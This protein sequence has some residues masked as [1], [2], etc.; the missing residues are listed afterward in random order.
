M[1]M[2]WHKDPVGFPMLAVERDLYVHWLP[3]TKIQFEYFMSDA[4]DRTFDIRWYEEALKLNARVTPMKIVTSNYWNTFLSGIQPAEAQRF[5]FWCGDGF[6][7]PSVEEW[8][9]A[10]RV[11]S[12]QPILDLDSL[13]A[14]KDLPSRL[15]DVILR[16]DEAS[17]EAARRLGYVRRLADQLLMR[18]G[19]LEWVVDDG[20]WGAMGEPYPELCGNLATPETGE[21]L[22]PSR[23]DGV[24]LP[25]F[26]FRLVY[27]NGK[28]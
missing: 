1:E 18:L 20:R 16:T 27:V 2:E 6:R 8:T 3:I 11:L 12:S 22:Y 21:P 15:R 5:A 26:G 7:L 10:Y 19:F 14:F 24:R 9:R 13:D 4:Y 23:P 28:S 25:C 17:A